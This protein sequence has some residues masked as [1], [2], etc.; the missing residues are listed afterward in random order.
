MA[1]TA[2]MSAK[3]DAD[4]NDEND[5]TD[6][7]GVDDDIAY[8]HDGEVEHVM[9]VYACR[10]IV[11]CSYSLFG[12]A[13]ALSLLTLG[14][15]ACEDSHRSVNCLRLGTKTKPTRSSLLTEQKF[16]HCTKTNGVALD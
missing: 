6:E 9:C 15:Y 4:D 11:A 10:L 7:G 12:L 2:K 13:A 1:T 16:W 8:R 3:M 5:D 14:M